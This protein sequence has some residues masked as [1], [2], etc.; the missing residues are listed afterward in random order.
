MAV[1]D[2]RDSEVL[3]LDQ[4]LEQLEQLF[5]RKCRVVELRYFAGL[6][7]EESAEALSVSPDTIKR[8]WRTAKKWL[9]QQFL[10]A[11]TLH[12]SGPSKAD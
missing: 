5:P 7:I 2:E 9:Q 10:T 11:G 6:S 8:E 4:A 12:G 3:A 1:S